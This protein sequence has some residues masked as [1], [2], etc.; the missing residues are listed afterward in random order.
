MYKKIKVEAL[1][2]Q[3]HLR[4]QRSKKKKLQRLATHNLSMRT[5]A[6]VDLLVLDDVLAGRRNDVA[7]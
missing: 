2:R 4:L 7:G 5:G 6:L 1:K 3:L